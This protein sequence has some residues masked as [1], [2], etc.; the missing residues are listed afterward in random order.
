ML[1]IQAADE[2]S[3]AGTEG[4]S[5]EKPELRGGSEAQDRFNLNSEAEES[6]SSSSFSAEP[7]E[8]AFLR[9]SLRVP[10]GQKNLSWELE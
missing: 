1:R 5:R 9:F 7:G 3:S 10:L 4:T 8:P 6:S 2:D